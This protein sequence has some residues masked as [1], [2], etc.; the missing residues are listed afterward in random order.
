MQ[1]KHSDAIIV[2]DVFRAFTTACYVLARSPA[3]YILANNSQVIGKLT[4]IYPNSLLIGKPEKNIDLTYDIPNSP[5]RTK[6]VDIQHKTILHRTEA[7]AKGI[8]HALK[9]PSS[10]VFA[11]GFVNAD[12][13][14]N[15]LRLYNIN[16]VTIWPMGHEATSPSLEDDI[17]AEY[18]QAS[19]RG[20]K[21]SLTSFLPAIRK[22][23]G[24]YFFGD[25]QWQYPREDFARCLSVKQF[26]FAVQATSQ[27]DHAVLARCDIT[28]ATK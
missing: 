4:S 15:Y 21:M 2:I 1:Q 25:D 22:G 24:R 13:T 12:A 10:I 3:H 6:E 18:I 11:A 5:T 8:L 16:S 7:G 28:S 27:G 19:L 20:E 14:V 23:P 26:N 17:C 9:Q